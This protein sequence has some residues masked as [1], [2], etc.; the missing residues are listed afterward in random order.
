VTHPTTKAVGF[1]SNLFLKNSRLFD[2]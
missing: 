2:D 1:L